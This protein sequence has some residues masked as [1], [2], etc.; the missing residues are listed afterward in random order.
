[1]HINLGSDVEV[2]PPAPSSQNR[3][4]EVLRPV[5]EICPDA[6]VAPVEVVSGGVAEPHQTVPFRRFVENVVLE[7][8]ISAVVEWVSFGPIIYLNIN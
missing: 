4:A 3:S 2:S 8:G 6:S 7:S 1:M 5:D